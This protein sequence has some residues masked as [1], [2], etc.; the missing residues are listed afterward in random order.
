MVTLHVTL[1]DGEVR[2]V[3]G[4]PGRSVM[5]TIRDGGID[6]VMAICGGSCSCATCHV[7]IDPAFADLMPPQRP[8]ENDLLDCSDYR[9]ETS[10]LSCQ[11]R[12]TPEFDGL[13][14]TVAPED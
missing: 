11:L 1:R 12:I 3:Q 8:D 13:R 7:Y 9:T 6:E 5:E 2:S 14:L 10:R 4:R